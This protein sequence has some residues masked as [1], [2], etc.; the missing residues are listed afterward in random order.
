[1]QSAGDLHVLARFI[2]VLHMQH[3]RGI[4]TYREEASRSE[5]LGSRRRLGE[6]EGL[7]VYWWRIRVTLT[8]PL[9]LI[10]YVFWWVSNR[11]ISNPKALSNFGS[12]PS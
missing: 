6:G 2:L 1:M 7:L 3:L 10:I 12:P 9:S 5:L 11:P 4:H 8:T